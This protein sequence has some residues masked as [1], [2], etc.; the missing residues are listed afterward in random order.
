MPE[1]P[2]QIALGPEIGPGVVGILFTVIAF[3]WTVEEPHPLF[4]VTVI[5][6]LLVPAEIEILFVVELP[7]HPLGNVQVYAVAPDTAVTL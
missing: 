2:K 1:L 3:V 7:V 4:A 6:P 5:L